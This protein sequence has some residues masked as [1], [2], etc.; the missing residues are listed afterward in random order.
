VNPGN[1]L[2]RVLIEAGATDEEFLGAAPAALAKKDPFTYVLGTVKGM[3][4]D[5]ARI[6]K[7]L[8]NGPLPT[9]PESDRQRHARERTAEAAG[10]YAQHIAA[11]A[12]IGGA[13]PI[14][15][16]E[17]IHVRPSIGFD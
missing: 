9:P 8:H 10:V 5:A 2:L 17:V 15:D 16:D 3:R 11:E 12:P 6:A 1:E 4:E 13:L 14:D 7:G